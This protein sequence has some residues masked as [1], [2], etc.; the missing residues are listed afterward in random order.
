[1]TN[2]DYI[3]SMDDVDLQEFLCELVYECNYCPVGEDCYLGHNGF[4]Y[5]LKEE[6]KE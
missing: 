6:R 4:K 5:W 3:R 2:A 1:M